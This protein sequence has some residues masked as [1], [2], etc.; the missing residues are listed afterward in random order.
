M[1]TFAPGLTEEILTEMAKGFFGSR[2][3]MDAL[4]DHFLGLVREIRTLQGTVEKKGGDLH[5]LLGEEQDVRRFY[6]ALGLDAN[7]LS[8]DLKGRIGPEN[9]GLPWA[10]T[11]GGRFTKLVLRRYSQLKLGVDEYMHGRMVPHSTQSK[12]MVLSL[13]YEQLRK[14]AY[15]INESIL[16]ME[17]KMSVSCII[18]LAKSYADPGLLEKEKVTGAHCPLPQ[19]EDCGTGLN[20]SFAYQTIDFDSYGIKSFPE[21]PSMDQARTTIQSFCRERLCREKAAIVETMAALKVASQRLP[22][23]PSRSDHF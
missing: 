14:F 23:N 4:L 12:R 10:W 9:D 15:H 11:L 3:H 17:D 2:R 1:N 13:H 19:G 18:R 7:V 20:E 6:T 8:F 5:I 16:K 22:G 21:L